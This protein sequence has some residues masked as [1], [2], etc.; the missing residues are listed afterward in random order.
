M[1]ERDTLQVLCDPFGLRAEEATLVGRSQNEVFEFAAS[2]DRSILRVSHGR[3]VTL[4]QVEAEL[5]WVG[6]L[7]RRGIDACRPRPS[8]AGKLCERVAIGDAAYLVTHFDRAPGRKIVDADVDGSLHAAVGRLIALMHAASWDGPLPATDLRPRSP[9]HA[10]RLV[11]DDV[12]RYTPPEAQP[13][14]AAVDRLV[15][16]LRRQ[17]D[18]R[19]GPIHADVGFSNLSLDGERLWVFD[20]DNCELGSVEQDLATVLYDNIVCRH[21]NRVRADELHAAVRRDWS[22]VLR[23]YRSVRPTATIDPHVIRQFLLLREAVIYT[24][25]CRTLDPTTMTNAWRA[26]MDQM[27]KNVERGRTAV[28]PE[29]LDW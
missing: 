11:R 27:R 10:S 2:A 19:L 23:G 13:F 28:E 12:R 1:L 18:G 25:Y 4:A 15:D 29:L 5:E 8:C 3:G 6:E 21:S 9:W 24:H 14:R 16:D 26:G 22:A 20:F 17:T 7:A